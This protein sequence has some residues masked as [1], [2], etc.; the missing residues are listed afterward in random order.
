MIDL[1]IFVEGDR[2]EDFFERIVKP[3]LVDRYNKIK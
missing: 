3:R 1:Y 2:D